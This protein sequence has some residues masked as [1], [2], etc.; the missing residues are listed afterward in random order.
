MQCIPIL[1]KTLSVQTRINIIV[2][3]DKIS[4]RGKYLLQKVDDFETDR[5]LMSLSL[6][7]RILS[8][9]LNI[10]ASVVTNPLTKC[11]LF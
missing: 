2:G 8:F 1:F 7:S 10:W 3:M 5:G 11:T 4:Q 6:Q 9:L